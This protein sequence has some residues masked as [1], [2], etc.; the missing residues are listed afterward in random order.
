M[1]WEDAFR[2]VRAR[3]TVFVVRYNVVISDCG[4]IDV[5]TVNLVV[6]RSGEDYWQDPTSPRIR[7]KTP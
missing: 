3:F 6:A 1:T 5:E 2:A 4:N 7:R